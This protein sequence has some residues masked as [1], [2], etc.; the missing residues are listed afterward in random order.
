MQ[1]HH[2]ASRETL[3]AMMDHAWMVA[4]A[5][6]ASQTA[7]ISPMKLVAVSASYLNKTIFEGWGYFG[8][9]INGSCFEL[10]TLMFVCL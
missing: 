1:H 3:S 8:A 10:A 2:G 9:L 5:V 6:M 7:E 4:F